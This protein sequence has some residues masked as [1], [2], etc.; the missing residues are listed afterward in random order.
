MEQIIIVFQKKGLIHMFCGSYT[1]QG[2]TNVAND[3]EQLILQ[4]I[5]TF[6]D[7]KAKVFPSDCF[8]HI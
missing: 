5:H 7:F 8:H 4:G 2:I 6:I 1:L 3:V